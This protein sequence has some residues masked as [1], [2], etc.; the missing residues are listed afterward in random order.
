MATLYVNPDHADADDAGDYTAAQNSSTPLET[1]ARAC[2][3]AEL[4]DTINVLY[5]TAANPE[6]ENG[7]MDVYVGPVDDTFGGAWTDANKN[8]AA[9]RITLQGVAVGDQV[10][11]FNGMAVR[12]LNNW[13]IDGFQIGYDAGSGFE[14]NT[15]LAFIGPTDF[16]FSNCVFTGGGANVLGWHGTNQV[17][18]CTV[19]SKLR[20]SPASFM[21]GAG[22]RLQQ[23][24]GD[25]SAGPDD[26]FEFTGCTFRDVQGEDAIQFLGATGGANLLVE[27][28]SFDGLPQ[29]TGNHTD[30]V[31]ATGAGQLIVRRCAF[32]VEDVVASMVIGT[33]GIIDTLIMENNLFV[34]GP[35]TGFSTQF[36]GVGEIQVRHNT[37]VRSNF[38]GLHFY[39]HDFAAPTSVVIVNNLID[40]F[41]VAYTPPWDETDQHHNVIASGPA[42]SADIAGFPEYGTSDATVFELANTP[43]DS[44]GIDDGAVTDILT[45][46]LGRSRI[47][48]PDCGCHESNP[49]VPVIVDPRGPILI[50]TTPLS[51]ATSVTAS[52]GVT[53][54]L[55]PKPGEELD[56]GTV[57]GS[58][59]VVRDSA[60]FTVPGVVTVGVLD[61]DGQQEIAVDLKVSLSPLIDGDLFP[62]VAY[63]VE[64]TDDIED[65][66]GSAFA[67]ASWTFR[68]AGPTGPA[69][70]PPVAEGDG[71][72]TI[73]AGREAGAIVRRIATCIGAAALALPDNNP[74]GPAVTVAVETDD[75][76]GQ[77]TVV[78]AGGGLNSPER[79]IV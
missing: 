18:D 41:S 4:G 46:R 33:D 47:S 61:G 17:Q 28:C 64:L 77:M 12:N 13:K 79:V 1:I 38:G 34:A 57:D 51:G 70:G 78:V 58:S 55:L 76:T 50:S 43:T 23:N 31:Q 22:F 32:G 36:G 6:D 65:T 73:A 59:V 37:W 7:E 5:A 15:A 71:V 24:N 30:G 35:G 3:L 39:D 10:P 9:G 75:D 45:D 48:A 54:T 26:W 11:K 72:V 66:E 25:E 67:G 2:N 62:L 53:A 56:A 74:T 21:E 44:A 42:T 52:T 19:T 63:T 60:G 20:P 68:V 69:I 16:L 14:Y 27:D 29:A 40:K 8:A 49:A